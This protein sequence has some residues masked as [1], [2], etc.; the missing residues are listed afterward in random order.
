MNERVVYQRGRLVEQASA[1]VGLC[2]ACTHVRRITSDR[3][4]VFYLCVLSAVDPQFPKYPR[5]AAYYALPA[6]SLG[7][8]YGGIGSGSSVPFFNISNTFQY[9]DSLTLTRGRHSL[10]IGADIRRNQ[11]MNRNG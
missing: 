6:I 10:K 1:G 5:L 11:N 9:V 8:N 2:G 3:G 7:T 4:S